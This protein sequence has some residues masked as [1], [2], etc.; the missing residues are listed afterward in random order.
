M[1]V[2]LFENM[3]P[4]HTTLLIIGD[5]PEEIFKKYSFET[6]VE[7]YLF[8][9]RKDAKKIK[10]RH[11]KMLKEILDSKNNGLTEYQKE[12]FQQ[13]YN[14]LH[15]MDEF[16]YYLRETK[17][18]KYDEESGDAYTTKNPN[19]HYEYGRCPQ[20]RLDAT[21]EESDFSNPF[22][23]TDGTISYTAKKGEI[24]W[25]FMHLYNPYVYESAWELVVDKREPVNET[26]TL[27]QAN[28]INRTAYFENFKSKEEYVAYSSSFWC[29]G[30]AKDDEYIGFDNANVTDY[31]WVTNF[32]DLYIKDLPDDTLLTIYE[33]RL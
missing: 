9:R 16:D 26:E 27:I 11:E 18:C 25:D 3:K 15:S 32:Y 8:M 7:P 20:K 1:K 13:V 28:M 6:E 4:R 24:R 21:N 2:T 29:Y 19:A 10:A 33:I 5:N 30:I 22:K 14:E 31:E 17:G 23:L 12:V